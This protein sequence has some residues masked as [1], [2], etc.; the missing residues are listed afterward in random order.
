MPGDNNKSG[1][2]PICFMIM[3][4]DK[5]PTLSDKGPA[6]IDYDALWYKALYPFI[7]EDLDHKAIRGDQD[8]GALIIKEMFERLTLSDLAIADVSTPN[9]NVYYEI[10]VRHAAKKTGCVLISAEWAQQSF[11][12]SQ[13]RRVRYPL[14]EGEITDE[15][16][17]AVREALNKSVFRLAGGNSPVFDSVPGFPEQQDTNNTTLF[18]IQLLQLS[19]FSAD[20]SVAR[21]QPKA[22][23]QAALNALMQNY[24]TAIAESPGVA[25]EL[26]ITLRDSAQWQDAVN[27]VNNLRDDIKGLTVVQEIYNLARSKTG[28]H[29][30]AIA[31]LEELIRLNGEN[32]ERLALMGGRYKR[33]YYETKDLVYLSKAITEYDKGMQSDMND[34]YPSSN[35]PMLYRIRGKKGDEEK[36]TEAATIALMALKRSIRL[37]PS[38][39]WILPTLTV[40]AFASGNISKAKELYY[41]MRDN[42]I[43]PF[44]LESMIPEL[45]NAISLT[46]DQA[47]AQQLKYILEKIK[48]CEY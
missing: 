4:Y 11:D 39:P 13:M 3:P 22:N 10:G 45:I 34:Y 32:S 12:I 29:L 28:K 43:H 23:R 47:I 6:I 30:E 48:T 37:N 7:E 27:Y 46:K 36:A 35:L 14:P 38:D 33:L 20:V 17:K 41:E 5:K 2:R 1:L 24:E 8:T 40:M 15:T 19:K 44:I 16:A 21:M 31:G 42:A 18:R 26:L 25:V 9:T